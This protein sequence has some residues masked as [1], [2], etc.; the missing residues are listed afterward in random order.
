MNQPISLIDS[1]M[2]FFHQ[3]MR[4]LKLL[5]PL[6]PQTQMLIRIGNC[7][8]LL[9]SLD[10]RRSFPMFHRADHFLHEILIVGHGGYLFLEL[11]DI[12][13]L[14]GRSQH[15]IDQLQNLVLVDQLPIF[16]GSNLVVNDLA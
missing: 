1:M 6:V 8:F 7:Y 16:L 11:L 12:C 15:G 9:N 10:W 5:F 14:L 13:P 3:M 4:L 2:L